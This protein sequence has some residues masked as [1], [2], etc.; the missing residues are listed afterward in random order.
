[1]QVTRKNSKQVVMT[2][3]PV[4]GIYWLRSPQRSTDAATHNG[5]IDFRTRMGHASLD[6]LRKMMATGMIKESNAPLS[7]T[8]PS[9]CRGCQHG[10]MILKIQTQF[11]KKIKLVRHNGA[12]E[13]ANNSIKIFYEDQ[14]IEQQVTVPYAHQTNGTAERAIRTIV[15]IG[16]S[17]LHH[18]NLERCFWAEAAMKAIYIKNRLPSPKI[19]HKTPFEIVYKSKPSIKHMRVFGC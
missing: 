17:L 9:V 15:T 16:R 11:G 6:A 10:K 7:S 8:E 14:G 19:D 12:H 5:A 18:A 3:D 1:M 4:D 2:A 13:F